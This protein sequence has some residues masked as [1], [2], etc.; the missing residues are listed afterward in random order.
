MTETQGWILLVEL[1]IVGLYALVML[2]KLL[3]GRP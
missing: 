1:G 2:L 3:A